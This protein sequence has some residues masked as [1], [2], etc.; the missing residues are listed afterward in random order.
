[1]EMTIDLPNQT[2]EI[3]E[4]GVSENFEIGKY[5]KGCLINNY[6]DIDYIL[7][8]TKEIKTFE[9]GRAVL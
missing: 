7:S 1:M 4:I 6:D 8:L 5:K 2:F 3:P 9:T